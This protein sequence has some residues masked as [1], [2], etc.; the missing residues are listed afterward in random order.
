[1]RAAKILMAGYRLYQRCFEPTWGAHKERMRPTPGNHDYGT[2]GAAGYFGYFGEAAGNPEEGWYSYDYGA[3]HVIVLNSKCRRVG[4]CEPHEPQA[5]WLEAD[6]RR[7]SETCQLAYFHRPP[8]SSGRYG[9]DK[10]NN[11]G[12]TH[13][14]ILM[15][16]R[17]VRGLR[18]SG[19]WC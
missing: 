16:L 19:S 2:S 15:T 17:P 7:T 4:G 9:D 14:T 12:T 8:F 1:M 18:L 10:R 6:L 5:Q 11:E 3:W 13:T